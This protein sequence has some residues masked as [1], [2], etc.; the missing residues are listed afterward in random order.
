MEFFSIIADEVTSSVSNQEILS[1]CLRYVSTDPMYIKEVFF[2]FVYLERKNGVS[3]A[4]AIKQCLEEHGIDISLARGQTYDGASAM[5]SK[6][7]G[8]QSIIRQ[9]A[10]LALYT[11]CKS[12]VLNLSIA[13]SCQL[14]LVRNMI[15]VV[16]STYLFFSLSPKRQRFFETVL[17]TCGCESKKTKVPGLCKTRWVERH[18]CYESFLELIEWICICLEAIVVPNSHPDLK[19][20]DW[21]FDCET[22]TKAQGLLAAMQNFSF[23][24]TLVTVH[25][26]LHACQGMTVK[27]Q[28]RDQ[29]IYRISGN[30]RPPEIFGLEHQYEN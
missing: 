2:D 15:D 11:H 30:F 20:H 27:L 10:P 17:T 21:S 3:I 28:K 1:V 13:A 18:N 29:N 16:N 8:V 25:N 22:K 23:V 19:S 14:P 12:H 26:C 4:E 24:I 9:K 6:R 5:S 7:I